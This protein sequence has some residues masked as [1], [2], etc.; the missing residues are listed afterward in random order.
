MSDNLEHLAAIAYEAGRVAAGSRGENDP[1]WSELLESHRDIV[2]AIVIAVT[3][4]LF[5]APGKIPQPRD[6]VIV[7][8]GDGLI[9]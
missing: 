9:V 1:P 2:R 4:E 7:R 6:V 3:T 5:G 8:D